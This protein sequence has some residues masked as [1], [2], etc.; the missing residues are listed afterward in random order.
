MGLRDDILNDLTPEMDGDLADVVEAFTLDRVTAGGWDNEND[1]PIPDR[2]TTYSGRG[3][4]LSFNNQERAT[5]EI[6]QGDVKFIVLSS[7]TD[8]KPEN[9]DKITVKGQLMTVVSILDYPANVGYALQLR[10]YGS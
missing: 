8:V 1:R 6:L 2:I 7:T 4:Y 3:F 10:K 9:S 5:M